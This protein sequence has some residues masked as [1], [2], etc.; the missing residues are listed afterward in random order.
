M[1]IQV[2]LEA[3]TMWTVWAL[4]MPLTSVGQHVVPELL[5]AINS[6]DAL[7]TDGTHHGRHRHNNSLVYYQNNV[8]IFSRANKFL[9]C[10]FPGMQ[11]ILVQKLNRW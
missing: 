10:Q 6:T 2:E 7:A 8:H 5:L 1:S 9:S 3:G 11:Y 4:E